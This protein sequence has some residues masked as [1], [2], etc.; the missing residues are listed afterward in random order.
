MDRVGAVYVEVMTDTSN[1]KPQIERAY[2]EVGEK[3]GTKAAKDWWKGFQKETERAQREIKADQLARSIDKSLEAVVKAQ[4]ARIKKVV[5]DGGQIELKISKKA[6]ADLEKLAKDFD[7]PLSKVLDQFTARLPTAYRKA[8]SDAERVLTKEEGDREK[9][10][11]ARE[12]AERKAVEDFQKLRARAEREYELDQIARAKRV[13][14]EEDRIWT[15]AQRE[16]IARDKKAAKMAAAELFKAQEAEA[17]KSAVF[18]NWLAGRDYR[19]ALKKIAA[20]IEKSTSSGTRK[21]FVKGADV[22]LGPLLEDRISRIKVKFNVDETALNRALRARVSYA[23]D[24]DDL[25]AFDKVEAKIQGF[26][27]R[28]LSGGGTLSKVLVGPFALAAGAAGFFLK[29]ITA[30]GPAVAKVGGAVAK[31]G[32]A[33]AVRFGRLGLGISKIGTLIARLAGPLSAILAPVALIAAWG[34][35][36]EVLSGIV[37]ILNSIAAVATIAGASIVGAVSSLALLATVGAAAATGYGLF[38]L[39]AKDAFGAVTALNKALSTGAKK[40]W[41]KYNEALGKLG[42]NA[43][44]A[45]QATKPLLESL[46]G[47][48]KELSERIFKDTSG[49]ISG[50]QPLIDTVKGVV[51]EFG[52]SINYVFQDILGKLGDQNVID[53]IGNIGLTFSQIFTNVGLAANNFF[54]GFLNGLNAISPIAENLS[55]AIKNISDRFLEWTN[56]AD[57][58]AKLQGWFQ[59]VYDVASGVYG[60]VMSLIGLVASLFNQSAPGTVGALA[61]IKAK[62]DEWKLWVDNNQDKINFWIEEGKRIAVEFAIGV[63]KVL[64]EFQKLNT[65]DARAG[66]KTIIS[67]IENVLGAIGT[68]AQKWA[69]FKASVS[70]GV[71]IGVTTTQGSFNT[72]SVI[73]GRTN[74][75]PNGNQ[76]RPW[77]TGARAAGGFIRKPELSWIGEAGPEVVIPLARPINM[78]DPEV[79]EL[80]RM[81][82]G[83]IGSGAGG[84]YSQQKVW[85]VTQNITPTSADPNLVA[86]SLLNRFA[87]AARG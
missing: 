20:D 65:E 19:D 5:R 70:Q 61:T 86:A 53:T 55:G 21:G 56:N 4:S 80:T 16:N 48:K 71:R 27:R 9:A 74:Y 12:R 40:D 30:I 13:A 59:K 26:Q 7:V 17:R 44:A 72:T 62:L 6:Y 49:L 81:V 68:V 37:V 87:V 47:V 36:S 31:F 39:G 84:G 34:A 10:R 15:A 43:K 23:P 57:N 14:A 24:P 52:Q 50:L 77:G 35:F 18:E 78:V 54:I 58:M 1:V 33:V 42:D 28:I 29:T 22:D 82:R 66:I 38:A 75:G 85:N 41:K 32:A 8:I 76:Q 79:R 25:R 67:L 45:V 60:V 73:T 46:R 63:G 64:T 83:A 51:T 69:E 3:Q 11:E 2:K